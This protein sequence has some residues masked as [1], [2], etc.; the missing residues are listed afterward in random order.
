[1]G[2]GI[3][4]D[5]S[6]L[7]KEQ[8]RVVTTLEGPLLVLAGAGSGKTKALT[9][10]IANILHE[11]LAHESEI[12][13]LTFTN[14][15]A[16]EMKARISALLSRGVN[17]KAERS[18]PFM[19]TFHSICVKILR[20]EGKHIGIS[21]NFII[22]DTED[23]LDTLKDAM[24]KLNISP[25]EFNPRAVLSSISSCKNELITPSDYLRIAQGYFQLTVSKI[26]PLYQKLLFESNALD[27]DDLIFK[28]VELFRDNKEVLNKYQHIFKYILVDEYQDTNHCQYELIKLLAKGHNNI[29]VVGDE[30]QSIYGFRGSDIRNILNFEK[31]YPK[32]VVIK[33]EQNYRSTKNIL[34]TANSIIKHNSER[35]DKKMWTENK[36]GELITLYTAE[37]EKDEAFYIVK[38]IDQILGNN[39][40]D[41]LAVLYRTNAQSRNMEEALLKAGYPYKL[42]GG[43][44][45]YERKEIKDII[46]YLRLIQN[47]KDTLSLIRII[48]TPRRGIGP[49]VVEGLSDK[50]IEL[51]CKPGELFLKEDVELDKK[52]RS[53]SLLLKSFIEKSKELNVVDLLKYVLDRTEYIKY[54]DDGTDEAK[55]R[56]ENIRELGTVASR[57]ISLKPEDSLREFLSDISLI[58]TE[59]EKRK[60]EGKTSNI[61]LM[62]IHAAKGLE[63]DHVF[64]IGMEEGLFPHTRSFLDPS[65][66]EEERRLAYV[67]VTRARKKLSL[68]HADSRLYFGQRQANPISRFIED[69]PKEFLD[70]K[71]YEDFVQ[72][73][74]TKSKSDYTITSDDWAGWDENDKFGN[75]I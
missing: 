8:Q 60:E 45:F 58:E 30:D 13:A 25:K 40:H 33:L 59:E 28:S 54:I 61:T 42:V 43:M 27:F 34:S 11:K 71:D 65:E 55:S 41:T 4:L 29:C 32:V 23:Q 37:N 46:A 21:Q 12:L 48:N 14:K 1:V 19:G 44:R 36:D 38:Q 5:I 31:D 18:L 49:K 62:T 20:V 24:S 63:F 16:G 26:Y 53:F 52:I 39:P 66:M 57:Y 67:A 75:Y 3:A 7:N 56:I 9:F 47:Q 17:V 64:V 72:K 10:R 50:A 51:K 69:I 15:A 74:F 2:K 68:L 22:Y 35:K 6:T 73:S 70:V